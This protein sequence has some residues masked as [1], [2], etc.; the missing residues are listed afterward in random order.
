MFNDLIGGCLFCWYRWNCSPSLFNLSFH[1]GY[2]G[3]IL[4]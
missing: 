3:N 1:N 2:S 4:R